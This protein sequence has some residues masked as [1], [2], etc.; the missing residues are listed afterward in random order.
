MRLR[1][2]D[3]GK[4]K[5]LESAIFD[6]GG[7]DWS[8]KYYPNGFNTTKDD[9]L[10]I[11]LS[12]KSISECVKTGKLLML[13]GV[14]V[15][16][17]VDGQTFNAHK[18][19]LAARSPVFSAQFFGLMKEKSDTT[20]KIEEMETPGFQTLLH[21]IYNDSFPGFEESEDKHDTKLMA[22]HLLVA[23]DR[24]DLERLKI[25]CEKILCDGINTSNVVTMLSLA[26]RHNCNHLRTTCL[27]LLASP[28]ILQEVA[29]TEQFKF[30]IGRLKIL[31]HRSRQI[32]NCAISSN[33]LSSLLSS[34]LMRA[35]LAFCSGNLI[36]IVTDNCRYNCF[37]TVHS[38]NRYG[39]VSNYDL[40]MVHRL[41]IFSLCFMRLSIVK[42]LFDIISHVNTCILGGALIFQ[43]LCVA[44]MMVGGCLIV[45]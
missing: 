31:E 10:S 1:N 42:I 12:H 9:E 38:S 3:I 21:F 22:Q 32:T 26:E 27:K 28:E 34:L 25:I 35:S 11:Y 33:D 43:I 14:D 37:V 36:L 29:A 41:T 8:I 16:F 17:K 15:T 23:A 39:T 45:C 44:E 24:Y 40:H 20:I 18:C 6:V 2:K 5:F 13:N 7:H 19:I 30:L 4:G